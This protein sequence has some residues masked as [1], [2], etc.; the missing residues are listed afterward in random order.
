MQ[1]RR[2]LPDRPAPMT[3]KQTGRP[4]IARERLALKEKQWAL[5]GVRPEITGCRYR[6]LEELV[7]GEGTDWDGGHVRTDLPAG[8]PKNC[9]ADAYLLVEGHPDEAL[10]YVEGFAV[11]STDHA[12][13]LVHHAWAVD[14]NGQIADPTWQAIYGEPDDGRSYCGIEF[15]SW[16]VRDWILERNAYGI[17]YSARWE[18]MLRDGTGPVIGRA[19]DGTEALMTWPE[20]PQ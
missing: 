11:I 10:T 6:S 14:M 13:L 5:L 15:P 2:E 8:T 20:G 9:F 12:G 4:M 16:F 19:W 3:G 17:F 18:Q 1:V 7:L